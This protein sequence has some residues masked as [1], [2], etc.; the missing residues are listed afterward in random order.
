M[1]TLLVYPKYPNTFWSFKYSL[2]QFTSEKASFPPLGLMTVGAMLPKDWNLKLVDMNVGELT[3]THVEWADLVFVSAMLAQAQS[4]QDVIRRCKKAG[5][6]IVVGG[7]AFTACHE[8]FSGFDHVVSGEAEDILPLFLGDLEKG[9]AKKIYASSGKPS[10]AGTPVPLWPLINFADY[11]TMPLQFS[12]GCPFNCEF[13]DII[14]MYGRRQRAK[15]PGQMIREF[16][17]LYEAGWKGSVFV[18]DDNLIGN[19]K[20]VKE[21]LRWLI[22]WQ[23]RHNYPFKLITEASVNLAD[24]EELLKLMAEA[25]FHEVFVGIETVSEGSLEECGK[26]QNLK[27]NLVE[28]VRTIHRHGLQVMGGFILG[29]D[30]DDP[31]RIFDDLI[32][33]IQETGVVIAMVGILNALPETRLWHRLKKE[34]RVIEGIS[35]GENTDGDTNILPLMGKEKLIRG[36]KKVITAIYSPRMYYAR[37]DAML[38]YLRPVSH[39]RISIRELKILLKSLW[40][41]GILAKNRRFLFW[42]LFGKTL[43]L[44]KS[45]FPAAIKLAVFGEHLQQFAKRFE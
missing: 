2:E 17:S 4:A 45:R 28:A 9:S 31:E 5:K 21:M 32:D 23:K 12:R 25:N 33:F 24:D 30:S 41:I 14:V 19:I 7:P 39:G 6:R 40:K 20:K 44:S 27:R 15:T 35:R 34:G 3:D 29:F 11:S 43:L 42:K 8:K 10:L 36:Y 18:V 13:C 22:A 38:K 1:N 16:Q 37:I 26:S